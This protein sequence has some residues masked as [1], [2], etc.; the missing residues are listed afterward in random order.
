[1]VLMKMNGNAFRN[2]GQKNECSLCCLINLVLSH[3]HFYIF[4]FIAKDGDIDDDAC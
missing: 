2:I 4:K 3:L 1:M